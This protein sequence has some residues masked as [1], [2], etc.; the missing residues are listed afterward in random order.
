MTSKKLKLND[1]KIESLYIHCLEQ[2]LFPKP[3]SNLHS[4]SKH[5][6]SVFSLQANKS[7]RN[8]LTISPLHL[9]VQYPAVHFSVGSISTCIIYI[10]CAQISVWSCLV[11]TTLAYLLKYAVCN[12][13]RGF[14]MVI[15]PET[16]LFCPLYVFNLFFTF[17]A[18]FLCFFLIFFLTSTHFSALFFFTHTHFSI[19]C[20]CCFVCVC[21]CTTHCALGLARDYVP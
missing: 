6:Y 14:A 20:C 8:T 2:N 1:D 5:W 21:F 13:L 16:F 17:C 19:C 15:W 3:S 9:C 18:S 7:G 4:H 10:M 11:P 12:F